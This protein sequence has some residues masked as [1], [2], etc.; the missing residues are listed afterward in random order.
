MFIG[1][2]RPDQL[3]DLLAGAD[4]ALGDDVLDRIDE[5][6]PPGVDVH[7]G[8]LYVDPTP[9]IQNK[10]LGGSSREGRDPTAREVSDACKATI[11]AARA[12]V[13]RY[14]SGIIPKQMTR[15]LAPKTVRNIHAMIHRALVDAVGWKYTNGN[16]ASNVKPP[17]LPRTRRKGGSPTRFRRS[18]CLYRAIGSP[19]CSCWN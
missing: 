2:R 10:R 13:R 17:R 5:I 4:A 11:H 14:K 6:V 7:T 19:R 1:P 9:P 16:P 3:D 18:S 12:A 8:D 15:G